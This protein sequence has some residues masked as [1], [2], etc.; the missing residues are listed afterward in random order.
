MGAETGLDGSLT[1]CLRGDL[2]NKESV[3]IVGFGKV[4]REGNFK[5]E[6][7]FLVGRKGEIFTQR[8]IGILEAKLRLRSEGRGGGYLILGVALVVSWFEGKN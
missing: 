6:L 1:I 3:V 8:K 2:F 4:F 5:D 7:L